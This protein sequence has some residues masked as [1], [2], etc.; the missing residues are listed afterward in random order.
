[1]M[2]VTHLHES[3]LNINYLH[4]QSSCKRPLYTTN[5]SDVILT[6]IT[7]YYPNI[8]LRLL[9]KNNILYLPMQEQFMSFGR[10]TIYEANGM[11]CSDDLYVE[12]NTQL[13]VINDP[14]YY[15]IYNFDNYYHFIYDALPYLYSY[16]LLPL[17]NRPKLLMQYSAPGKTGFNRF[18]VETLEQLGVKKEDIIVHTP[19]NLYKNVTIQSSMT[20]GGHSNE[21]PCN[22]CYYVYNKLVESAIIGACSQF[23]NSPKRIYISRRTHLHGDFSNIGTD[24]TQRRKMISEDELVD[25]LTSKFGFVEVFGENMTMTEK[26]LT[27]ANAE[28]VVGAIGGGMC[29]LLF[30]RKSTKSLVLLSPCFM[31]INTRFKYSMDHTDIKYCDD[32]W[33]IKLNQH[34]ALAKY[35]RVQ[36]VETGVYGEIEDVIDGKIKVKLASSS[37]VSVS[38]SS[39]DQTCELFDHEQLRILDGGLNSPWD[40]NVDSAIKIVAVSLGV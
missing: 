7:P 38:A 12:N 6:G 20:H 8:L 40:I 23:A 30:S 28:Y 39:V 2:K 13:T 19:G 11:S 15:F 21:P 29:N 37:A 17:E 10:G 33:L 16:L 24:Y 9:G 26:I 31:E 4:D 14:V 35:M 5:V 27:F 22:E 34:D 36:V 1:M 18:V 25:K 3:E 32:Y